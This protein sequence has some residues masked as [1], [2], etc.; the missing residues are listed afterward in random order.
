MDCFINALTIQTREQLKTIASTFRN[1]NTNNPEEKFQ[2]CVKETLLLIEV[3]DLIEEIWNIPT[4]V[5]C[6]F[7]VSMLCTLVIIVPKVR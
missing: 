1:I 2:K 3:N 6:V 4:I 7:N 5:T